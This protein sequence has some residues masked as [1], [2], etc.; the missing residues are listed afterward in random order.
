M[1]LRTVTISLVL[2]ARVNAAKTHQTALHM[3][4]SGDNRALCKLLLEFGAN[5]YVENPWGKRPRDLLLHPSSP[6]HELLLLYES[7]LFNNK[8]KTKYM[9]VSDLLSV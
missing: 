4:A 9:F 3:A 5:V 7:E 1:L 6:L 2:G 8:A